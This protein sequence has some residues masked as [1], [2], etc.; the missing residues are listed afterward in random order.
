MN[1][2]EFIE[3]RDQVGAKGSNR[4]NGCVT[5]LPHENQPAF[6]AD[7]STSRALWRL[8]LVLKEIAGNSKPHGD[9]KQKLRLIPVK[10]GDGGCN[11]GKTEFT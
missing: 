9:E 11:L 4:T 2:K 8:S 10:D 5:H 1:P 7:S 3:N 6:I